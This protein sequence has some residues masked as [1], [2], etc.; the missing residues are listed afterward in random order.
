M[1]IVHL[2]AGDVVEL[3]KPH[4]CASSKFKI[5]RV[6]SDIRLVCLGCGRDMMLERIKVEKSIKKVI[7]SADPSTLTN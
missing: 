2:E 3:K 5:L 1:K 4:P 6:G 7:S